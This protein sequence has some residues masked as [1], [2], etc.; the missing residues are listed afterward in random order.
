MKEVLRKIVENTCEICHKHEDEVGI[1]QAHHINRN[2]LGG[3]FIP[4]NIQMICK[5]CHKKLHYYEF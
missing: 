2:Y 1:L 5:S 4:R 3:L